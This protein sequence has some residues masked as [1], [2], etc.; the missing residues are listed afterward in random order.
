[1][2]RYLIDKRSWYRFL[3][4]VGF[5]KTVFGPVS[6]FVK[7]FVILLNL[8]AILQCQICIGNYILV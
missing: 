1:M 3:N 6:P 2:R 8:A 7:V 5:I 4:Y